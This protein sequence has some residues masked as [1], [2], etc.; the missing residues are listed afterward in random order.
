MEINNVLKKIT[1]AKNINLQ[2]EK[3]E[4]IAITGRSESENYSS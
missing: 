3:C 1:R 2:I 4:F